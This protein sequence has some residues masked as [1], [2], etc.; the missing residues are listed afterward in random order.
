[1]R[2]P[3]KN[4]IEKYRGMVYVPCRDVE[5]SIAFPNQILEC[6]NR[7]VCCDLYSFVHF[8]AGCKLHIDGN[9]AEETAVGEVQQVAYVKG[10]R[11]FHICRNRHR[12]T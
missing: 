8:T 5:N 1:M 3:G 12:I 7:S 4:D 6:R 11:I 9:T 10:L 2:N